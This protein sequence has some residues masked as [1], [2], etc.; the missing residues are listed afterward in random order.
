[1]KQILIKNGFVHGSPD[2]IIHCTALVSASVE[3][4]SFWQNVSA[5]AMKEKSYMMKC[6][7]K[8]QTKS[9]E[10]LSSNYIREG[11]HERLRVN[12]S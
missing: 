10:H 12:I 9:A 4:G 8:H 2:D 6:V 7:W 3:A 1:M 11:D 5:S